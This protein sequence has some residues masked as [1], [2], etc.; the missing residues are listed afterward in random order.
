VSAAHLRLHVLRF[1]RLNDHDPLH[2][3]LRPLDLKSVRPQLL[4]AQRSRF[5]W[6]ISSTR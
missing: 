1:H 4:L 6:T 5:F 3:D 2:L